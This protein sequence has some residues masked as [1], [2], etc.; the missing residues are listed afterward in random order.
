MT[1]THAA[2]DEGPTPPVPDRR[3]SG[4]PAVPVGRAASTDAAGWADPATALGGGSSRTA[5][6]AAE[7]EPRLQA[8]VDWTALRTAAT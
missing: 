8:D 2:D 7:G 5:G 1:D 6:D 4:E 3:A